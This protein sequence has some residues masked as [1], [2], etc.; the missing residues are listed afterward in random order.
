M[1][2]CLVFFHIPKTAGSSVNRL[3]RETIGPRAMFHIG[4]HSRIHRLLRDRPQFEE[5]QSYDFL[6]FLLGHSVNCGHVRLIHPIAGKLAVTIRDPL[7]LLV[8]RINYSDYVRT[9]WLPGADTASAKEDGYSKFLERNPNFMAKFLV[10]GFSSMSPYGGELSER[11][12]RLILSCFTFVAHQDDLNRTIGPML[13]ELGI[14]ET[15]GFVNKRPHTIVPDFDVDRFRALNELDYFIHESVKRQRETGA[16]AG[17]DIFGSDGRELF[18]D[19]VQRPKTDTVIETAIQAGY[20]EA[21]TEG[22]RLGHGKTFEYMRENG[23]V[24]NGYVKDLLKE[25]LDDLV[26][27]KKHT[28]TKSIS[29]E[30]YLLSKFI[31]DKSRDRQEAIR[32]S[33]KALDLNPDNMDS[34]KLLDSLTV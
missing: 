32:Y 34:R 7:A 22:V 15:P 10:R 31:V 8:S 19:Y 21:L 12:L 28:N 26:A 25:C 17:S 4:P 9:Q 29:H 11:N 33:R 30:Y 14:T 5:L 27:N 13:R 20:R 24:K 23:L 2:P 18:E 3:A 6:R 16:H 1:K